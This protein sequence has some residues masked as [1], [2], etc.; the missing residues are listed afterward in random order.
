[1]SRPLRVAITRPAQTAGPLADAL[2]AAGAE[3]LV[4]PLLRI[5]PPSDDA[6]LR[7]AASVLTAYDWIVFTSASAVSALAAHAV[8]TDVRAACVGPATA[9]ALAEHDVRA[10]VPERADADA[11][12][13][14]LVRAA[15]PGERVLWPR[16]DRADLSF[17]FA[18]QQAG[19]HVD[20]PVAYRTVTDPG[21]AREL[22]QRVEAGEIHV[23]V[24]T[25]PS[26]VEVFAAALRGPC[27]ARIVAIGPVTA[28]AARA[29]GL[30]V[31]VEP[32]GPEALAAAILADTARPPAG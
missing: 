30:P 12:A 15:H 20:A 17:A 23:V 18:L 19:L 1:M 2:R 26:A 29:A 9:A 4:L 24:L 21:A 5:E 28:R 13:T 32:D 11:L 10:L 16:G 7:A 3:P 27:N 31:H 25:A 14:A 22:A 6:P 8:L